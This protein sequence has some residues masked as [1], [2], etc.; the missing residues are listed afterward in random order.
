MRKHWLDNVSIEL[1]RAA[2]Q[3]DQLLVGTS[4]TIIG[5]LATLTEKSKKFLDE[6]KKRVDKP[7]IILIGS[8]EKL[9]FFV[10]PQESARVRP[11]LAACWPG[12]LTV[13]FKAKKELPAWMKSPEGT[14][15]IRVPAH[16]GLQKLLSR[17]IGLFSTSANIS[18]RQVPTTVAALDP[19]ILK[20][21]AYVITDEPVDVAAV[22]E[23]KKPSTIIDCTGPEIKVIRE[24]AYSMVQ[25]QERSSLGFK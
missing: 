1:F 6:T 21:V 18:G 11:L 16:A 12:P 8:L 2:L 23:Q 22:P 15:A 3:K 10:D 19:E 17:V 5:F 25:L 14:I 7:Y 20:R 4:D 9:D 24:G 13:I